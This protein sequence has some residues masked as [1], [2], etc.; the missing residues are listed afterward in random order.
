MRGSGFADGSLK[1]FVTQE[2]P[3]SPGVKMSLSEWAEAG[4]ARVGRRE[5]LNEPHWREPADPDGR[6]RSCSL[7]P[8]LLRCWR[9]AQVSHEKA[10]RRP[11]ESWQ[12]LLT[13]S[14]ERQRPG[15]SLVTFRVDLMGLVW[16]LKGT[17]P[18]FPP[19]GL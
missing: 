2:G 1:R 12:S 11:A 10:G 9:L 3:L 14:P 5:A 8:S 6:S 17:F 15:L 4:L 13:S 18:L 19:K 7:L 16:R